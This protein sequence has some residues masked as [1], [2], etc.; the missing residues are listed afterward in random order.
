MKPLIVSR[1]SDYDS[2]DLS[3][4]FHTSLQ[5]KLRGVAIMIVISEAHNPDKR[6]SPNLSK[7]GV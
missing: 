6:P 5:K 2:L 3:A 1:Y 7:K 4:R